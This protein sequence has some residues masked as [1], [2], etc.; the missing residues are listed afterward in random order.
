M[1]GG[2]APKDYPPLGQ[3]IAILVIAAL[4][5]VVMVFIT[6]LILNKIERRLGIKPPKKTKEQGTT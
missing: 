5:V 6:H 3:T 4:A 2:S 1:W